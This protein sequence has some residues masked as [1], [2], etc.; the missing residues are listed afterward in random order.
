[1]SNQTKVAL[2]NSSWGLLG[3]LDM[4]LVFSFKNCL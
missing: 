4:D 1:M 3:L 2:K